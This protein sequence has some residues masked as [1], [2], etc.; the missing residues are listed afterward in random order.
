LVAGEDGFAIYFNT[1]RYEGDRTRGKDNI[2]SGDGFFTTIA[3]NGDFLCPR[4]FAP[5][6]DDI[7]SQTFQAIC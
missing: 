3:C 7:D 6:P 4:D 1:W 2:L 5:T